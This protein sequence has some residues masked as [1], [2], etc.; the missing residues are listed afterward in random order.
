M[1]KEEYNYQSIRKYVTVLPKGELQNISR[2]L[3][4]EYTKVQSVANGRV[5][6]KYIVDEIIRR[7]KQQA[8]A[9]L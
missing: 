9:I 3:G 7:A 6:K 8:K 5:Y 4:I 2:K 1:K